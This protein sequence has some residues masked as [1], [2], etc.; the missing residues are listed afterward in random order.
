[1]YIYN[2]IYTPGGPVL[3]TL[4]MLCSMLNVKVG[5]PANGLRIN[6]LSNVVQYAIHNVPKLA[7]TFW[8]Y[9]HPITGES[10]VLRG[11]I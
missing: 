3:Y 4:T 9:L 1:M 7:C 5:K 10:P 6:T 11:C 2:I 8:G